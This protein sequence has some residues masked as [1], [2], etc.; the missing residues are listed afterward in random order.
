[1]VRGDAA[2]T[3]AAI[4]GAEGLYRL[5]FASDLGIAAVSAG[6]V[7]IA[8]FAPTSIDDASG[9]FAMA[10]VSSTG[11]PTGDAEAGAHSTADSGDGSCGSAAGAD[12]MRSMI[13][14]TSARMCRPASPGYFAG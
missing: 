12:A 6:W 8:S 11:D 10:G 7:G 1:M 2:A 4:R 14:L 13:A 9:S 3:A 5:G